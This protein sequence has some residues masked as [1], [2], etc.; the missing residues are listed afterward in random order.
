MS[1]TTSLANLRLP[2]IH[3]FRDRHGK[4]RHYFRRPGFKGA[5]LPGLAGSAEFMDA[6]QAALAGSTA[7]RIEIG[8]SRTKPGSVAAAV[9]LYFGSMAFGNLG[10]STQ[11]VRRR[12]LERFREAYGERLFKGLERPHIEAMLAGK[13][14]TPHAARHFLNALRAVTGVAITANLR[15]D[16]PTVGIRVKVRD[17]GGFRTWTDDEIAQFEAVHPIGSRARLAFALLLWTAQRRGD[18]IRMGR[19]HVRDGYIHVRQQKTGRRLWLPILPPLQEVLDAHPA[20]HLTFLTTKAGEPFSAS[21]FTSW[22]R[23]MRRDAGLPA[24]L[25]AHGLRK[26]RSR[27][28]A[29]V[30]CSA[31]QIAAITGHATL[32][33]VERYTKAADQKRLATAA[34]AMEAVSQKTKVEQKTGKP[35][36]KVCQTP[37]QPI[38]SKGPGN[39]GNVST[40]IRA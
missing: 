39:E 38:E 22:F 37:A 40:W 24:G 10:P 32:R 26:A 14:A 1:G 13:I 36:G 6:Y 17:T 35:S 2:Y 15:N 12:I 9:A 3:S 7:P 20:G 33:E 8:A 5:P 25:S 27:Q 18:V 16:D 30:G 28:L 29:E 31:N 11:S 23:A 34:A 21:G 4:T 19:Q